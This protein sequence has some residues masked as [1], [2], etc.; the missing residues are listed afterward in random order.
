[1][2]QAARHGMT[3]PTRR[4]RPT[5]FAGFIENAGDLDHSG[6]LVELERRNGSRGQTDFKDRQT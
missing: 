3:R 6:L 4:S 2:P 1:M 5:S